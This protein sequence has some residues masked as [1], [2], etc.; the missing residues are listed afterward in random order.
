MIM[1]EP[2]TGVICGSTQVIKT[3]SVTCWLQTVKAD[4]EIRCYVQFFIATANVAAAIPDALRDRL[5]I[6]A[7]E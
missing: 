4:D 6:S 7:N 5:E 2:V 1:I 3:R